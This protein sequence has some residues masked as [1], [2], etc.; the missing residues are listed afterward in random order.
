MERVDGRGKLIHGW[1][2]QEKILAH[3]SVG[4][5]LSH[6]GWNSTLEALWAGKPIAAWPL[7]VEQRLNA[8]LLLITEWPG[9]CWC[10]KCADV[11]WGWLLQVFGERIENCG[12]GAQ[13]RRWHGGQ[14]GGDARHI[15]AHE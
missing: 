11:S 7:A 2:P 6:C 4:G 5:F 15:C 13:G 10:F 8:R 14:S 9:S 12:G 3:A 1:A